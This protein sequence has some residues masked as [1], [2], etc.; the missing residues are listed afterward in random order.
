MDQH[1]NL[2]GTTVT[3]NEWGA[4]YKL[5]RVSG[6]PGQTEIWQES[7]PYNFTGGSDGALPEGVILDKSGNLYGTTGSGGAYGE[8]VV[9]KLSPQADGKWNYT[10]LHT[11]NC[12]DGAA[13]V[14]NLTFGPDGKLYG[15][16]SIGGTYGGGV[17]FQL[18]P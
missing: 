6:G 9:F 11:F 12:Q 15:T 2:Y 3:S 10:L 8:G 14:G 4:V 13:P 17:V 18:T 16:T 5:T 1:G 7:I